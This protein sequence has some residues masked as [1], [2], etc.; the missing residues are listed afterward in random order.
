MS[1]EMV[2]KYRAEI[3]EMQRALRLPAG[4]DRI[5][6]ETTIT[7]LIE[8][9]PVDWREGVN[10]LRDA[11]F[12]RIFSNLREEPV[13]RVAQERRE[14]EERYEAYWAEMDKLLENTRPMNPAPE[15][16]KKGENYRFWPPG[17]P[18]PMT[19]EDCRRLLMGYAAPW[20][21]T[22]GEWERWQPGGFELYDG[23]V[24]IKR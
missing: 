6:D 5:T 14:D 17:R 13:W 3:E 16:P 2:E 12:H 23:W 22:I 18:F 21:G 7:Q 8:T 15:D 19:P 24:W 4:L 1:T 11:G 10:L 9:A 20:R